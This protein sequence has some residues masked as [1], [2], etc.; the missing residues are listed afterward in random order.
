MGTFLISLSHFA[1]RIAAVTHDGKCDSEMRNVPIS[2]TQLTLDGAM[3]RFPCEVVA[4]QVCEAREP[5]RMQ[6]VSG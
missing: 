4:F 1:E 2:W 6:Y 5:S 3:L